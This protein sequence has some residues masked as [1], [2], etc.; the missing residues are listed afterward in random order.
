MTREFVLMPEFDKQWKGMGLDDEDLYRLQDEL[1]K[2]PMIGP[3][4]RGTGGLRKM[5][6]SLEGKGKS[7]GSRVLYVDFYIHKTIFLIYAYPKSERE[8][9]TQAER[10]IYRQL[11]A[12]LDENL[13]R[14]PK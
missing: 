2:N 8:N 1:L 10:N 4:M 13:G 5:R 3:V 9:I 7:G 6:F 11:I 12:Q 14:K